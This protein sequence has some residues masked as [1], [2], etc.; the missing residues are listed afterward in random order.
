MNGTFDETASVNINPQT[1]LASGT[2][3]LNDVTMGQQTLGVLVNIPI[4]INDELYFLNYTT[5]VE[6]TLELDYDGASV[7][8][9][10]NFKAGFSRFIQ[11]TNINA[12]PENLPEF[13]NSITVTGTFSNIVV[14]PLD[15]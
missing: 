12:T 9:S 3:Q 8:G 5:G 10:F 7:S 13:P 14:P 11:G 1:P 2:Y 6:G 15:Q 4:T